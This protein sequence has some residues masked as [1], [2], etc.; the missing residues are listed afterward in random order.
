M[1]VGK[2]LKGSLVRCSYMLHSVAGVFVLV[3][4]TEA[5]IYWAISIGVLLIMLE[6]VLTAKLTDGGEWKW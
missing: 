3:L 2:A 6:V 5:N 1:L 4:F